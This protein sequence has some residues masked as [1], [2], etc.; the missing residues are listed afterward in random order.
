MLPASAPFSNRSSISRLSSQEKFAL[1]VQDKEPR[2]QPLATSIP[3]TQ[4]IAS[5]SDESGSDAESGEPFFCVVIH[6]VRRDFVVYRSLSVNKELFSINV[7][8]SPA[9]ILNPKLMDQIWV[10][11]V[12]W[13]IAWTAVW[14]H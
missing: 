4:S 9:K 13:F 12:G 11:V 14:N 7:S 8:P 10:M 6:A 1:R 2:A 5:S 3:A